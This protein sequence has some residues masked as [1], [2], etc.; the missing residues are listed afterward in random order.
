MNCLQIKLKPSRQLFW[1]FCG[2]YGMFGML[3]FSLIAQKQFIAFVFFFCIWGWGWRAMWK[4][5]Q[6]HALRQ[7]PDAV[8]ELNI[9]GQSWS[10]VKKNGCSFKVMVQ[11][12]QSLA[13]QQFALLQLKDLKGKNHNLVLY[14]EAM[15]KQHWR[16]L[17]RCLKLY[18]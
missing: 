5:I 9:N 12:S 7:L 1:L 2:G 4:Q 13:Y 17:H 16:K 18:T 8:I 3:I 15:S 11:V 14:R 10:I 6:L